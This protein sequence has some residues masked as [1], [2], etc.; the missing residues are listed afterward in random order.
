MQQNQSSVHV[1]LGPSMPLVYSCAQSSACFA[2]YSCFIAFSATPEIRIRTYKHFNNMTI[3]LDCLHFALVWSNPSLQY[4]KRSWLCLYRNWL[5]SSKELEKNQE[6]LPPIE[7]NRTMP[8][9]TA[10]TKDKSSKYSIRD[11]FNWQQ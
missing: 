7:R 3:E 9:S 2:Q 10:L 1:E 5:S 8:R 6:K 4:T 11:A